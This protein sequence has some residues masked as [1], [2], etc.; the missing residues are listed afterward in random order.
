MA[1]DAGG[2]FFGDLTYFVNVIWIHYQGI[3]KIRGR[4]DVGVVVGV[5]ILVVQN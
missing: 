4:I 3:E 5:W 1:G 2:I